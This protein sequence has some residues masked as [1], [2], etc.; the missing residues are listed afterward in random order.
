[1]TT[2]PPNVFSA[3]LPLEAPVSNQALGDAAEASFRRMVE[4]GNVGSAGGSAGPVADQGTESIP[5]YAPRTTLRPDEWRPD[6]SRPVDVAWASFGPPPQMPEALVGDDDRVRVPDPSQ[7]PWRTNCSL[8]IL[9][10]D[11]EVMLGTA[12]FIG[13]HTLVTAGHCVFIHEAQGRYHDW[14]RAIRVMPGRNGTSLPFGAMVSVTFHS[15]AGW[16]RDKDPRYDYGVIILPSDLGATVGW[17]GIGALDDTEL[18][19]KLANISGYPGDKRN[20]EDGT[21]WYDTRKIVSVDSHQ[22]HYEIDTWGGQSGSAVYLIEGEERLAVGIHAYGQSYF[23]NAA[24]RIT[25]SVHA[26]LTAWLQ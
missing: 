1:M 9:A 25:S 23:G 7:Y 15:V 6:T 13:P 11:G 12:W 22:I 4:P 8:Q 21:Q 20:A 14:A 3:D 18:V 24:T 10:P 2:L 19:T 5:G 17:V 26:N 16:A